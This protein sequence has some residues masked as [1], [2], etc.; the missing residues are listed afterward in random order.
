MSS[1]AAD[2]VAS[3]LD[4]AEERGTVDIGGDRWTRSTTTDGETALSRE[5][6]GVTV[7]VTGSATDEELRTVA[8][9]VRPYSG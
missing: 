6:D 4:G 5:A 8:E 2:P 9:A 3:V 7:L 1:G